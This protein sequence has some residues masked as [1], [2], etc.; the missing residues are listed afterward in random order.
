M[1]EKTIDLTQSVCSLCTQHKELVDVLRQIGF[2]DITKPGMLSTAG[3]FMT[4]PNGAA[5]KKM[6]LNA[7]IVKLIEHGYD[8]SE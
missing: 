1:G 8:I 7:I 5:L 2:T 4:I 3:R 6:D